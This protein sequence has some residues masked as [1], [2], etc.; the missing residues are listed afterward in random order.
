[1][2]EFGEFRRYTQRKGADDM[3]GLNAFGQSTLGP[4]RANG[5][6]GMNGVGDPCTGACA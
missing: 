1:M 6:G 5:G 4:G 3:C 2:I